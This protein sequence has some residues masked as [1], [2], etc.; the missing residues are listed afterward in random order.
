MG[1]GAQLWW[2][3]IELPSCDSCPLPLHLLQPCV[4]KAQFFIIRFQLRCPEMHLVASCRLLNVSLLP[5]TWWWCENFP[6]DWKLVTMQFAQIIWP[7]EE[8]HCHEEAC[9]VASHNRAI[10][11]PSL[12]HRWRKKRT[13]SGCSRSVLTKYQSTKSIRNL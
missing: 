4:T 13:G 10:T 6:D 8:S 2:D 7:P 12:C 3:G 11:C 5:E 9:S 1:R